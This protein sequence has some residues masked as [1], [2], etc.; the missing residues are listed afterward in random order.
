MSNG[1]VIKSIE[2]IR[3]QKLLIFIKYRYYFVNICLEELQHKLVDVIEYCEM[4]QVK[5]DSPFGQEIWS[6]SFV[7][8]REMD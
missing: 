4:E 5:K 1:P 8:C 6:S 3:T 2:K 7:V